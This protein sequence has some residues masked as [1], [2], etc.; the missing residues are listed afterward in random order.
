MITSSRL[1][2]VRSTNSRLTS[3]IWPP[4]FRVMTITSELVRTRGGIF[5]ALPKLKLALAQRP[6][7]LSA[8]AIAHAKLVAHWERPAAV[9]TP[10]Q[11]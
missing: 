6:V 5:F 2:P 7:L 8:L 1:K 11:W 10:S 3:M 4:A 9:I